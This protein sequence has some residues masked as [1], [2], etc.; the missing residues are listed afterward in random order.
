MIWNYF[1]FELRVVSIVDSLSWPLLTKVVC[2]DM[3]GQNDALFFGSVEQ[4]SIIQAMF[5]PSTIPYSF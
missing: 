1:G 4:I 5:V 3:Q 2:S